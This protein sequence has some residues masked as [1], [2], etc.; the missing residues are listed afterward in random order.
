MDYIYDNANKVYIIDIDDITN[1]RDYQKT[2]RQISFEEMHKGNF[3]SHTYF[4][5]AF[6]HCVV[7]FLRK[8]IDQDTIEMI[9]ENNINQKRR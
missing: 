8:Y 5:H 9:V 2:L 4:N 1:D 7:D 6:T 3:K